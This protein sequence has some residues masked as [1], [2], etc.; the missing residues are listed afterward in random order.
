MN[1]EDYKTIQAMLT[2]G[3]RFVKALAHAARCADA[4]NLAKI[5]ECW[6]DEWDR[7]SRFVQSTDPSDDAFDKWHDNVT[8]AKIE[9]QKKRFGQ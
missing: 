1:P 5:K 9:E 7:Y 3:G 8:D 6:A 2:F 4:T